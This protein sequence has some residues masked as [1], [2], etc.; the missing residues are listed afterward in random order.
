MGTL[1]PREYRDRDN[2]RALK[3]RKW[4]RSVEDKCTP[5]QADY[6]TGLGGR[7]HDWTPAETFAWCRDVIADPNCR[8]EITCFMDLTKLEASKAIARL[9]AEIRD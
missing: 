5:K 6:I 1:R 4:A 8:S 7:A 3:V 9:K 2:E